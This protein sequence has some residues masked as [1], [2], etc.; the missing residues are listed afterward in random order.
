MLTTWVRYLHLTAQIL[1]LVSSQA[2][3]LLWFSVCL[4][5]LLVQCCV[6]FSKRLEIVPG[7]VHDTP[8]T[9]VIVPASLM[10]LVG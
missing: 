9:A 7:A 4:T 3:F 8:G 10:W 1:S 2:P 6:P 5:H